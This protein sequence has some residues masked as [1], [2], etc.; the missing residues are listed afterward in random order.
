LIDVYVAFYIVEVDRVVIVR[1]LD[2]RA[3][4]GREM[5]K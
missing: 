4:I 5:S 3:D 2:G 1:V